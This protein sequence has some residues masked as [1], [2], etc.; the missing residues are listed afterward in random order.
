MEF[1]GGSKHLRSR[2]GVPDVAVF[3]QPSSSRLL[4]RELYQE[5]E[6]KSYYWHQDFGLL[7]RGIDLLDWP[8]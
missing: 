7:A 5:R 8:S 1:G 4:F 3:V 2:P 6:G